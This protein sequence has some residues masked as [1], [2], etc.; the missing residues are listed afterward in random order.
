MQVLILTIILLLSV[1]YLNNNL[2]KA[3]LIDF[4]L[5]SLIFFY[6]IYPLSDLIRNTLVLSNYT[7]LTVYIYLLLTCLILL[8]VIR[9]KSRIAISFGLIIK[10][11]VKISSKTIFLIYFIGF[12][13][14]LYF[15]YRYQLIFRVLSQESIVNTYKMVTHTIIIPCF[16]FVLF[17]SYIQYLIVNKRNKKVLLFYIISTLI[18]FLFFGRRE[19]ILAILLLVFV[20][21]FVKRKNLF[22][23]TNIFKI[24]LIGFVIILASNFYQ[25]VRGEIMLYSINGQIKRSKTVIEMLTDFDS[26]N[27]NLEERGSLLNLTNRLINKMD[28]GYKPLYGGIFM[29]AIENTIPSAFYKN[30]N[31][32]NIDDIIASH[33]NLTATD[34]GASKFIAFYIDFGFLALFIYPLYNVCLWLI[35]I[36]LLKYV[37]NEPILYLNISVLFIINVF[38]VESS[39][40]SDFLSLRLILISV[41]LFYLFRFI[42]KLKTANYVG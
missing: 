41:I 3:T 14:S 42:T 28:N 37:I 19:L 4:F 26:S 2:K 23:I 17:V 6:V 9:G 38:N 5:G 8:V 40:E 32:L 18:Y 34:F 1:I 11:A 10:Q 30:K 12:I 16:Y 20:W 25:N 7:F 13:F 31:V 21:A 35:F 15:F 22:K 24:L 27:D 29:Q 39:I 33:F 36:M